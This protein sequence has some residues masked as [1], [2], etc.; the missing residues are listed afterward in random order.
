MGLLQITHLS[1]PVTRSFD[2]A[3]IS[4]YVQDQLVTFERL[5]LASDTMQLS[6][7]GTMKYDT[8][9]LD[10]TLTSS[11]P[12]GLKL[13]P[14]TDLIDSVRDQLVTIRVTGTLTEPETRVQQL[15]GLAKAWQDVF[16]ESTS[17]S[18]RSP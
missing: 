17:E 8:Q 18:E 9:A 6:G 13:G 1:L 11:N 4:Y 5:L 15:S 16:G 10:L 14:V 3:L 7:R 12:G 2:Q